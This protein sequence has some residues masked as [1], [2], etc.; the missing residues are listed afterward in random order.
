MPVPEMNAATRAIRRLAR[1]PLVH[2]LAIGSALFVVGRRD[3]A[4][5]HAERDPIIFTAADVER[6]RND[7]IQRV[8]LQPTAATEAK[9]VDAAIDEE[10]LYREALA[11]GL[12][13]SA[14]VRDRLARLARFV[15]EGIE[16]GAESEA[17]ARRLGLDQHDL[18]I[19]RHL[20][21]SMR[22]VLEAPSHSD[23]PTASDLNAYYDQHSD[24]F[25]Q[26]PRTCFAQVFFS[27]DRRGGTAEADAKR[28]LVELQQRGTHPDGAIQYGDP[29]IRGTQIGPA[30]A[31]E[32][33]RLFGGDFAAAVARA[34]PNTW[35][36]PVR[37]AYGMHLVWINERIPG[38]RPPLASVR[39]QVLHQ[40]LHARQTERLRRRLATLRAQYPIDVMGS[41]AAVTARME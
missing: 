10:V 23:E 32:I 12:D 18:V 25:R 3:A 35:I 41:P 33:E 14:V 26:P 7:W 39:G 34:E 4:P 5:A 2:F 1:A 29:F 38:A 15:D 8:G 28:A 31:D 6:V 37:S 9:L 21:N 24:E 36:G 27:R 30:T 20:V 17:A 19:R 16:D 22:L 13:R 11:I 40:L